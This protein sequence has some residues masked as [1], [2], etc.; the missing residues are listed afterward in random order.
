[1]EASAR[2]HGHAGLAEYIRSVAIQRGRR[3]REDELPKFPIHI[4]TASARYSEVSR[5]SPSRQFNSESDPSP[6]SA[7]RGRSLLSR[8]RRCSA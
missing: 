4:R 6:S 2:R 7:V 3:T 5:Q 1:V 8:V